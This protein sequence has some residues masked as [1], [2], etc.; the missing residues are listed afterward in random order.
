MPINLT[1]EALRQTAYPLAGSVRML[2]RSAIA[3]QPVEA[4]QYVATTTRGVRANLAASC[5]MGK[6]IALIK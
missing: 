5:G 3:A 1:H 6:R 4:A 2:A